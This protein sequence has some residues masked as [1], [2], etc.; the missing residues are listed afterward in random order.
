MAHP[1]PAQP[2]LRRLATQAVADRPSA[3]PPPLLAWT[4][5]ICSAAL[6]GAAALAALLIVDPR[7][8][9]G[10][11]L[12][13]AVIGTGLLTMMLCAVAAARVQDA[14]RRSDHRARRATP[15]VGATP[16]P[17][18]AHWSADPP[19]RPPLKVDRPALEWRTRW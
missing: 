11:G 18:A 13:V 5:I 15:P 17:P 6:V 14:H 9:M 8:T 10:V 2:A 4:L 19:V 1:T 16:I 12:I 3:A 7:T